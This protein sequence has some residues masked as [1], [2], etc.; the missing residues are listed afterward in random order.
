MKILVT[1]FDPFGGESMNPSWEAVKLL[2]NTIGG[3]DVVKALMPC[4]FVKA[5][6]ELEKQI[7]AH[8]PDF[9]LCVGQAGGRFDLNVEKVAINL[10]DGRI[11]DNEGYQ[12][13]D[14]IIQKDG[15]TA[16]F[17][18]LPVKAMVAAIREVGIP[19]SLSYTAGSYVCNYIMYEALYLTNKKH[20]GVKAG[21][22]H[23]PFAPVQGIGKP[24]NTP[25]MSI[26]VIAKGIEA[27]IGAIFTN[28]VDIKTAEG[29]TH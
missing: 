28:T 27:A 12:P 19:A 29:K 7:K 5:G 6:V 25:T 13:I 8:N 20:P 23:I 4:I 18:T 17:A 3:H 10:M 24:G 11:A 22:M 9:V 1:G 2:P 14:T 16:Y 21:F 26:D 15:D